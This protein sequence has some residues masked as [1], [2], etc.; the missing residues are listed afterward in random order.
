[1]SNKSL[2]NREG[3]PLLSPPILDVVDSS[4][5]LA[6]TSPAPATPVVSTLSP[7]PSGTSLP[8]APPSHMPSPTGTPAPT[9]TSIASTAPAYHT[10]ATVQLR[11]KNATRRVRK[12]SSASAAPRIACA[13]GG[14]AMGRKTS[15]VET[16][17]SP[18]PQGGMSV[19][20]SVSPTT[21][22][23]PCSTPPPP[24]TF[25]LSPAAAAA[26]LPSVAVPTSSGWLGILRAQ[27]SPVMGTKRKRYAI[28]NQ[29]GNF[30]N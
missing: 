18:L 13:G 14:A 17:I 12:R 23:S 29:T 24:H 8:Y 15:R 21:C 3:V 25:I 27:P 4:F 20:V 16:V 6:P 9:P 10:T 7:T 5:L 28:E 30:Q 22:S 1:M 11:R 2:M 26:V 19:S